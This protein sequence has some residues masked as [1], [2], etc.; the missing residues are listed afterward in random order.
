MG[1]L[2]GDTSIKKAE[3]P[4]PV[5]DTSK[6]GDLEKIFDELVAIGDDHFGI[7]ALIDGGTRA[8]VYNMKYG[9][10]D[11]RH[12]LGQLVIRSKTYS[13]TQRGPHAFEIYLDGSELELRV[14]HRVPL[15]K[16][17][18]VSQ[19]TRFILDRNMGDYVFNG[20]GLGCRYWVL[21]LLSELGRHG[22]VDIDAATHT[23]ALIEQTEGPTM[24]GLFRSFEDKNPANIIVDSSS[25]SSVDASG[26]AR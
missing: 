10:E 14:V 7:A 6:A 13:S 2:K 8:V 3:D 16:L 24:E 20:I 21:T 5:D 22:F 12:S 9:E 1:K 26:Y 19:L 25:M 4:L 17:M 11:S 15:L 23:Q 18:T